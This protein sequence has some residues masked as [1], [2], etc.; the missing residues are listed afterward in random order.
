[1]QQMDEYQRMLQQQQQQQQQAN[2]RAMAARSPTFNQQMQQ[3]PS[4]W[5]QQPTMQQMQNSYSMTPPG[6]AGH[7]V[8][9]PGAPSPTNSQNWS[10]GPNGGHYPFSPSPSN[11]GGH[12]LPDRVPTPRHLSA[13]PAPHQ[14]QMQMQMPMQQQ[15]QSSPTVEQTVFGDLDLFNWQQ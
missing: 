15:Q 4:N 1:M 8:T 7:A 9:F 11:A 2:N 13:T 12:V 14:H 10:Q 3:V 5:Q 6:S